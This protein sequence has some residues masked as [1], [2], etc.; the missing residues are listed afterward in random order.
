MRKRPRSLLVIPPQ[1]TRIPA[2]RIRVSALIGVAV[3]LLLG[4]AGYFI[5]DQVATDRSFAQNQ[6]KNLSSQ[7]VKLLQKIRRIRMSLGSV[8]GE[9][10]T[11]EV[12]RNEIQKLTRLEDSQTAVRPKKKK[13]QA[14]TLEKILREVDLL[15]T[16]ISGFSARL[17]QDP[18]ILSGIPIIRPLAGSP[19]VTLGFGKRVDPF[20]GEIKW[21]NG[22]DFVSEKDA[23]VIAVASGT[24]VTAE[25]HPLWGYRVRIEHDKGYT[26]VYAHLGSVLVSSGKKVTKGD[27]I[28]TVGGTGM[29]SGPHLHYEILLRDRYIN[30]RTCFFP[31]ADSADNALAG[32]VSE[33]LQ[34]SQ[35]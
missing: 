7:N 18:S 32:V 19:M 2:F 21:H 35:N 17:K 11:L 33:S 34:Q 5:P 16:T 30:P 28:G 8:R 6:R 22:I 15:D 14:R 10:E 3:F 29:A 4:F 26:T 13:I 31:S 23:P 1:R 24:V 27:I 9:I 20:T 25:N 12:H